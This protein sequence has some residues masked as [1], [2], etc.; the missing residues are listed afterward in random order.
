[1]QHPE[2]PNLEAPYNTQIAQF[3]PLAHLRITAALQHFSCRIPRTDRPIGFPSLNTPA[4]KVQRSWM[5]KESTQK[6]GAA[7]A[8]RTTTSPF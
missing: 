6:K 5:R 2:F 8:A 4:P 7:A 3:H 1:M